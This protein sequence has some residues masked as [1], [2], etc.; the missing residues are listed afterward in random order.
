MFIGVDI[1]GAN[2]VGGV[3]GIYHPIPQ[4]LQVS[5]SDSPFTEDE[6]DRE[7]SFHRQITDGSDVD[8]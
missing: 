8:D 7:G 5:I 3:E 1:V 6:I 4:S 2:I